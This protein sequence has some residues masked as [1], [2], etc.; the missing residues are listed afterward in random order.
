MAVVQ[1]SKIQVRKGEKLK[2]GIPQ[3]SGGEFAW[4][5]DTQELYIGNG[6]VSEG[7][8]AVGNT[9]IL[10][11]YD[12][13]L[14]LSRSYKFEDGNPSITNSIGRSLQ[15]KLDDF[16]NVAD[17]GAVPDVSTDSST[18]FQRALNDLYIGASSNTKKK[19]YVPPGQYNF[20]T[21]LK[22]PSG[23]VLEGE[24]VE[25]VILNFDTNSIVACTSAG[26][27]LG[28]FSSTDRPE[29]ITISNL[30]FLRSSGQL[31]LTGIKK[32]YIENVKFQ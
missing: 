1:I 26:T 2:T 16:V 14:D 4:A 30:T 7:A 5:V 3:L 15:S 25:S 24:S 13:I 17:Y 23:T 20:L 11:E 22:I 6:P 32:A 10:T 12:N 21:N 28:L 18:A 31:V 29:N 27:V 8:P 19:L 9:K